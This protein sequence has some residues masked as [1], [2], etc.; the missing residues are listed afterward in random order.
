MKIAILANDAASYVKPMADGLH[1]MLSR[2][3][4]ESSVFYTGLADLGRLSNSFRQ[5]VTEPGLDGWHAAKR[6]AKYVL[7]ETPATWRF[8]HR[9]R[10]YDAVVVVCTIPT[11]F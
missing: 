4:V 5:Y 2:I 8:I 10:K 6:A 3:G 11:A 7:K 1:R 9:L